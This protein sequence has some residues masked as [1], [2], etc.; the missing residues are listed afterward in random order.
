MVVAR[1]M[2][3]ASP[4]LSFAYNGWGSSGF[5]CTPSLAPRMPSLNYEFP[6]TCTFASWLS[7]LPLLF[8]PLRSS[9][10]LSIMPDEGC[11]GLSRGELDALDAARR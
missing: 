4:G 5:V 2:A 10:E 11:A 8:S 7:R 9:V 1:Q 3:A 6:A